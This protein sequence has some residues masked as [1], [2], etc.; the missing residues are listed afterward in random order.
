VEGR[1]IQ[2]M[3]SGEGFVFH[4]SGPGDILTQTRNQAQLIAWINTEIGSRE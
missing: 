1:S 3:K 4:F 2:S